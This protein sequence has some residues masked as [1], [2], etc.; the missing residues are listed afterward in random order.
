MPPSPWAALLNMPSSNLVEPCC[1]ASLLVCFINQ[2]F[3]LVHG[4]CVMTHGF[5]ANC[6]RV[7]SSLFV[8]CNCNLAKI[9]LSRVVVC[10]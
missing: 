2:S 1:C 8:F 10:Q 9:L 7:A 4:H 5:I 3:V 6:K